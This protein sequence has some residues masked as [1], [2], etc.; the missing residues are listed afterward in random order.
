MQPARDSVLSADLLRYRFD[1]PGSTRLHAGANSTKS[2]VD[3]NMDK[4]NFF[5]LVDELLELDRGTLRGPEQLEEV[6]WSSVSVIGFMALVD[7]QF[8]ISLPPASVG[9]CLTPDDLAALLGD[10]IK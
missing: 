3:V 5:A 6:G 9:G 10:R 4:A 7:E 8:G 1:P 2:D